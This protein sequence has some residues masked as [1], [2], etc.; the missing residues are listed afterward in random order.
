MRTWL[1]TQLRSVLATLWINKILQHDSIC[2]AECNSHKVYQPTTWPDA[3]V[4][5]LFLCSA[6]ILLRWLRLSRMKGLFLNKIVFRKRLWVL[7]LNFVQFLGT[8]SAI[9]TWKWIL[10]C[11]QLRKTWT[12][13]P[14][15]IIHLYRKLQKIKFF[16]LVLYA[17]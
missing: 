7:R 9:F 5:I 1:L 13:N 10:I 12:L 6:F 8:F 15:I 3:A 17:A 11:H 14:Q 16:S 2:T 4:P